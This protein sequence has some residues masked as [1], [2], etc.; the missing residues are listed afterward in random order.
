MSSRADIQ[1]LIADSFGLEAGQTWAVFASSPRH[2]EVL[3]RV[4]QDVLKVYPRRP[5]ACA[6]MSA[7]YA[8]Y[9]EKPNVAPAYVV[10]GSLYI[11]ETRVF[12]Q[13]GNIDGKNRFS[14]SNLSWNGHAWIV[15]GDCLADVSIFGT[16]Y[17]KFSPPILA[18]CVEREF[19]KGKELVNVQHGR[20][21][22]L[23]TSLS[24]AIY[25]KSKSSG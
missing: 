4:G 17:S 10:A 22:E 3:K 6:L 2:V 25:V 13:D 11:E 1:K 16:A 15:S 19:G 20:H 9:L 14:T 5:G 18:T 21:H 23:W 24:P 7:L 8:L 12:G